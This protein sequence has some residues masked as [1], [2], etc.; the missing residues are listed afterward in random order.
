MVRPD[1]HRLVVGTRQFTDDVVRRDRFCLRLHPQPH[2][3][4][5]TRQ[6][7]RHPSSAARTDPHTRDR[8]RDCVVRHEVLVDVAGMIA[9]DTDERR[10]PGFHRRLH[11]VLH[12]PSERQRMRARREGVVRVVRPRREV[13]AVVRR[14]HPQER[15][16]HQRH[17]IARVIRRRRVERNQ[18]RLHA[19]RRRSERQREARYVDARAARARHHQRRL[20]RLPVRHRHRLAAHVLK[21]EGTELLQR[22]RLCPAIGGISGP[23]HAVRE[24]L[25]DPAKDHGLV[26]NQVV[27]HTNP[28][29]GE[30]DRDVRPQPPN[31]IKS[32]EVRTGRIARTLSPTRAGPPRRC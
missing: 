1:D 22:P 28:R 19:V 27:T 23:P 20:A 10:S 24:H 13:V 7:F 21:P 3:R 6:H 9:E 32:D 5:A 11:H 17:R 14:R 12:P 8:P 2:P 31:R 16:I 18:L 15:H 30:A 29:R 25:L 4:R 26:W